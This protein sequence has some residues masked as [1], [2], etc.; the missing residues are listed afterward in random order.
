MNTMIKISPAIYFSKVG[1]TKELFNILKEDGKRAHDKTCTGKTTLMYASQYNNFNCA[2]LLILVGA[3]VNAVDENGSTALHYATAMGN[4]DLVKLL[5]DNGANVSLEDSNGI[6]ALDIAMKQE[7][8][9]ISKL[10]INISRDGIINPTKKIVF[11]D[12]EYI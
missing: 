8:D 5:V 6:S 1:K 7:N 9:K 4:Y 3:N 2:R 10:L 12:A 11:S